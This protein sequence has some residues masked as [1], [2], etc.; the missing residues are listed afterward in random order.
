MLFHSRQLGDSS[1]LYI[2]VYINSLLLLLLLLLLNSIPL[3]DR[4]SVAQSI[5]SFFHR[6]LGC[7]QFGSIAFRQ[8]VA[9]LFKQKSFLLL[10]LI[11]Q[12]MQIFKV[13][14]MGWISNLQYSILSL[15]INSQC[16]NSL[17][18]YLLFRQWALNVERKNLIVFPAWGLGDGSPGKNTQYMQWF[19]YKMSSITSGVECFISSCWCC[20]GSLWSS[21]EVE[22]WWP[23]YSVIMQLFLL[24]SFLLPSCS[25]DTGCSCHAFPTMMDT[26]T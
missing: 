16:K 21:Q 12:Y 11:I 25:C 14:L 15:L 3:K 6:Y 20:L 2:A 10:F 24:L 17:Y 23:R 26:S 1:I 5:H 8:V 13:A 22:P 4:A 19:D 18:T 9:N 7:L